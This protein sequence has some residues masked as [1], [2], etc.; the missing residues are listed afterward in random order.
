MKMIKVSYKKEWGIR[1]S[2]Y[3]IQQLRKLEYDEK[4][5]FIKLFIDV[6]IIEGCVE[7]FD[8]E[9]FGR[10]ARTEE[11]MIFEFCIN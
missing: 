1:V 5:N 4:L 11:R 6:D 8:M 2:F 3:N 9:K 10:F 7:G